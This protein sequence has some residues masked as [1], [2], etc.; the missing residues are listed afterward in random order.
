MQGSNR[1]AGLIAVG[2]SCENRVSGL[3]AF[4]AHVTADVAKP[5]GGENA[6]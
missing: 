1:H 5:L 4:F 6:V 2:L 3:E